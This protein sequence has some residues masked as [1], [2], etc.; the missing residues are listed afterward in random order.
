MKGKSFIMKTT[1]AIEYVEP[2]NGFHFELEE[3]KQAIG[4]GY[5]EVVYLTNDL[6][7]IVDEDGKRKR[8]PLNVGASRLY[9]SNHDSIVGDVLVCHRSQLR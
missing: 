2:E 4:G 9:N 1:G 5:I 3:L 6:C 8:M 7:M